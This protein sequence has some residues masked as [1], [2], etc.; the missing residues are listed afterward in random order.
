M[1]REPT[2]TWLKENP[3]PKFCP[4]PEAAC[5]SVFENITSD[6]YGVGW[7]VGLRPDAL[8]LDFVRV[9][10]SIPNGDH[11]QPNEFTQAWEITPTE[12]QLIAI[13]LGLAVGASFAFDPEFRAE[14]GKMRSRKTLLV[15]K[16]KGTK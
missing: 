4:C 7:C 15:K 12:A 1:K 2:K 14:A 16:G 8:D 13:G 9:C 3:T 5:H 11:G 6:R 10:S